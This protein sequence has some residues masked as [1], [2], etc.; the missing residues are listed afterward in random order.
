MQAIW[1]G[2]R[3]LF[4][5]LGPGLIV[6]A[7]CIGP[8]SVTTAS[9]LGSKFGYSFIWVVLAASVAMMGFTVMSG[10]FGAVQTDSFLTIITRRIGRWF[11]LLIGI[12][13][14]LMSCSYQI[15]NNLGAATALSSLTD[16][17]T[18]PWPFV[19]SVVALSLVLLVPNL[20]QAV[21]KLMTGL[22]LVM[23]AAFL[24]N[25]LVVRPNLPAAASGLIPSL[26]QGAIGTV[27]ALIG[28]TVVMHAALYQSYLVQRKGWTIEELP[29]SLRDAVV[30]IALVGLITL[31]ILLT[32]AAA[33]HPR[34]VVIQSAADMASQLDALF[35]PASRIVFCLGLFA[36]AF[37]SLSINAIIGGGLLA[38]S[39]GLGSSM[40]GPWPRR[41]A[42]GIVLL[43]MVVASLLQKNPLQA[44]ILAQSATLLVV[45]AISIGLMIL[46]NDRQVMGRYANGLVLNLLGGFGLALLLVISYA[47]Y[48]RLSDLLGQLRASS[49]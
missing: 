26:P 46:V 49:G 9:A 5:V 19:C 13:A 2:L 15:G 33:L 29:I 17:P 3:G 14:F 39:L 7:V 11:A 20:Y 16:G 23:I 22:V 27:A 4:V 45:P 12:S 31:L 21:E 8:G 25:L 34:G 37:S 41:F 18:W 32:S 30:G 42:L 36:A 38:D 6:A 40:E 28:T 10:R 44:V 43:G 48:D 24:A 1:R 47:T 35:G